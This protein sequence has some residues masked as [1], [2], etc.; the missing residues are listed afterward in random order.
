MRILAVSTLTKYFT[1]F[2]SYLFVYKNGTMVNLKKNILKIYNLWILK[3]ALWDSLP[4]NR[5]RGE[6]NVDEIQMSM[7][8]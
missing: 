6:V 7:S 1:I 4:N 5:R 8:W 2:K 3:Y